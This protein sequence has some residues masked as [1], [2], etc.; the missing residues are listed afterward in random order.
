MNPKD[1]IAATK[2]QLHLVP[3]ASLIH[4]AR[5]MENGAKKYG[6]FNWRHPD[7]KVNASVYVGAA[8]RHLASWFDGEEVA[9]DSGVHHLA[10]AKACCGILLD[11]METGHLIDDRP[12]VGA[13]SRLLMPVPRAPEQ[14]VERNTKPATVSTEHDGVAKELDRRP[15][16]NPPCIIANCTR[17]EVWAGRCQYHGGRRPEPLGD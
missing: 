16:S 13:A 15:P 3:P 14:P 6:P 5:A 8:L 2:P 7:R 11:A 1:A 10:H 9:A 17:D 4:E 12:P